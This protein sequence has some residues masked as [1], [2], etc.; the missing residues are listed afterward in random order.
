MEHWHDSLCY[1]TAMSF[2]LPVAPGPSEILPKSRLY[3]S[4]N[5][6]LC[7][8]CHRANESKRKY[9]RICRNFRDKFNTA[10]KYRQLS[11]FFQQKPDNVHTECNHVASINESIEFLFFHLDNG[12]SDTLLDIGQND[13]LPVVSRPDMRL[14]TFSHLLW[15]GPIRRSHFFLFILVSSAQLLAVSGQKVRSLI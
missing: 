11:D 3:V 6:D 5:T 7:L 13:T 9:Q 10:G 14:S 4:G 2:I 1:F 8:V 12:S 15:T